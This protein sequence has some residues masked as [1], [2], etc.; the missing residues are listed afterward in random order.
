MFPQWIYDIHQTVELTLINPAK[1]DRDNEASMLKWSNLSKTEYSVK[2]SASTWTVRSSWQV[3]LGNRLLPQ[4][5]ASSLAL[6]NKPGSTMPN[7]TGMLYLL[8]T[9]SNSPPSSPKLPKTIPEEWRFMN[10]LCDFK[11]EIL[12]MTTSDDQEDVNWCQVWTSH[13]CDTVRWI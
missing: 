9:F 7:R 13:T 11:F 10:L 6:Y 4:S 8:P 1:K 2:I 3:R 12:T 5:G